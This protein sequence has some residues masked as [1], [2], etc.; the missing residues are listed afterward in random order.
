RF[1]DPAFDVADGVE[2]LDQLRAIAGPERT[3]ERRG[4]LNHRIEDALVLADAR[5][6]RLGIGARGVAEHPLEHGAAIVL[7]RQ[8][9]VRAAPS[10]A[11]V[12]FSIPMPLTTYITPNRTAGLAAVFCSAVSAGT[13]PSSSGSASVAPMPRSR[14]RRGSD[15]LV[16]N[17]RRLLNLEILGSWDL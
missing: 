15:F 14:V 10:A 1:L 9:R 13:M 16:T 7:R 11:G 8:R 2:V 3:A 4:F 6:P 17:I 5:E 12:Q